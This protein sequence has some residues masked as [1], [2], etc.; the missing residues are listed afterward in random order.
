MDAKNETT[1]VPLSTNVSADQNEDLEKADEVIRKIFEIAKYEFHVL[2]KKYSRLTFHDAEDVISKSVL[3]IYK[4]LRKNGSKNIT[5]IK[6]YTK[7][8]MN[9]LV[10]DF[11]KE[12]NRRK[13]TNLDQLS[14]MSIEEIKN[15]KYKKIDQIVEKKK[16]KM[17]KE[18]ANLIVENESKI[19]PHLNKTEKRV[20]EALKTTHNK[21]QIAEKIG[22]SLRQISNIFKKIASVIK[23]ILEIENEDRE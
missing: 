5:A 2:L 22:I 1:N 9:N 14:Q 18:F 11:M 8:T 6:A 3:R 10:L 13:E 20:L 7:K 15:I 19:L 23:T 4:Q 12:K 16:H 17:Q 21:K